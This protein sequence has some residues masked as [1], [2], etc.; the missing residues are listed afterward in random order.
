MPVRVGMGFGELPFSGAAPFWD[1]I[2][3]LE[4]GGVNSYWQSDRIA[5]A[6]PHL[7][8]MAALGAVAGRTRRLKF[9]MNVA[10]LAL[11]EPVLLAKQC[12]TID[13]LSAGR[14]L[15]A[16]GI[17]AKLAPDWAATGTPTAG[18][19]ARADEALEIIIRLWKGETL[20]YDGKYFQLK[21]ARISPTPV[22]PNIPMWIGGSTKAAVE[23]TAKYGTGWQA[24]F[25]SPAQ[26]APVVRAIR[27]TA[28]AQGRPVADDHFGAAFPFR[29]GSMDEEVVAT[30]AGRF[31]KR[32]RKD[33]TGYF[34]VG[35]E[36]TILD[37]IR[38]YVDAGAS[39]F[40]LRPIAGSDADL[41]DQTRKFIDLVQPE[42]DAIPLPKAA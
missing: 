25:E 36:A 5:S 17:G 33:P 9:G 41:M 3:M 23:R 8:P 34:V 4:D 24:A 13:Y 30:E 11:R 31:E 38:A 1:W 19:G 14:L 35:D 26:L 6:R 27:E 20:D 16:F 21:G 18:R 42:L 10:S 22:N 15:P 7:E 40:I 28:V 29:F 39:K 32:L 37:R 12:A 2:D